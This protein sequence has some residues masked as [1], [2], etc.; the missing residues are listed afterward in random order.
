MIAVYCT[1]NSHYLKKVGRMFVLNLGVK[2]LRMELRNRSSTYHFVHSLVAANRKEPGMDEGNK[3]R[4][5]EI[6][7]AALKWTRNSGDTQLPR[8]EHEVGLAERDTVPP[9]EPIR[10]SSLVCRLDTSEAHNESLNG[11]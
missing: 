3:R 7:Q 4:D 5:T 2:S 9:C 8:S 10:T 1:A 11:S 6:H